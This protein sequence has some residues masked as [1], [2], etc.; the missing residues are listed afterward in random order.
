M[1]AALAPVNP[2]VA[3]NTPQCGSIPVLVFDGGCP[4]CRHF[5]ELTAL[6]S[7]I[8]G[9]TIRNGRSDHDLRHQLARRGYR[10]AD[11]AILLVDDQVLHGSDAVAWVCTQMQTSDA[12]LQ[13]LSRLMRTQRAARRLYPLL[14][15]TRQ[16]ALA[17]RGLPV[18]PDRV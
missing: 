5:A 18:D 16:A 2:L 3:A 4:F 6:R 11:G 9:L 14:L 10:L 7:G 12:L 1:T 8:P 17:L 15:L 13:L